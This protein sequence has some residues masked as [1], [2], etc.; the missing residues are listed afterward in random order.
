MGSTECR[1]LLKTKDNTMINGKRKGC[2][3]CILCACDII[4]GK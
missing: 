1:I 3:D 2:L 4:E